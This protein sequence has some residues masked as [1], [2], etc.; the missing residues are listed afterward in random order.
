MT[1]QWKKGERKYKYELKVIPLEEA[2]KIVESVPKESYTRERDQALIALTILFGK[3]A[4]EIL[5]IKKE[6]VWVD[7]KFFYVRFKVLKK[8]RRRKICLKCNKRVALKAKLCG[9]CGSEEFKLETYGEN[10]TERVKH[11]NVNHPLAKYFLDWWS[12]VPKESYVF[13]ALKRVSVLRG[14]YEYNWSKPMTY[15][16]MWQIFH[17]VSGVS[18]H[19]FRHSLATKLAEVGEYDELDLLYWFDWESFDTA[20]RYIH[21][22]GGKR[23]RK[24]ASFIG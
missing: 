16:R 5:A 14:V 11:K 1:R 4:N 12:K 6:S 19:G 9:Y 18:P 7:E 20:R 13:S 15:V 2:L 10:F 23:V 8:R 21:R 22:G 24:I 3:R 17:S